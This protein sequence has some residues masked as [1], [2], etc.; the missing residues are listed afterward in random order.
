MVNFDVKESPRL[1]SSKPTASRIRNNLIFKLGVDVERSS[2]QAAKREPSR[3]SLLGKVQLSK[4]PL[5][6]KEETVEENPEGGLW[7]IPSLFMRKP[8]L[9]SEPSLSSSFSSRESSSLTDCSRSRKLSFNEDVAV[10]PIP[11]RNEYSK[12]I[13][14]KLW[15][16]PEEMMLNAHRNS[17]EFAAEGWDWRSAMED[18]N[19]YRSVQTNELIHP[20]HV[21]QQQQQQQQHAK[22]NGI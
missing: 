11:M 17:V 21:E 13:K 7:I 12:R 10:C 22:G 9:E 14:D 4:E 20:V 5:K 15:S 18:E 1:Q 8:S 19:M 16:S 6:Y 2:C 3:G